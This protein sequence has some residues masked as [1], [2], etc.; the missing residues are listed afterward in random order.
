MPWARSAESL[1][2]GSAG[3]PCVEGLCS[4][5]SLESG[6]LRPGR[7]GCDDLHGSRQ[8]RDGHENQDLPGRV[9]ASIGPHAEALAGRLSIWILAEFSLPRPR[10]SQPHIPAGIP[11]GVLANADA[12]ALFPG[13]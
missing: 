8:R 13:F 7:S 9:S 12:W 3:K 10:G 4:L 5:P 11:R 2:R 1:W 6:P